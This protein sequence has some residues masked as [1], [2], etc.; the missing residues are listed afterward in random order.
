M[1]VPAGFP[2]GIPLVLVELHEPDRSAREDGEL[3]SSWRFR[4]K[5]PEIMSAV[6]GLL[7]ESTASPGRYLRYPAFEFFKKA[8]AG[9]PPK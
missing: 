5:T 3:G 9:V 1:E 6:E 7:A 8:G 4:R 2:L